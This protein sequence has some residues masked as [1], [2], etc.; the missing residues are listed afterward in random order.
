MTVGYFG[1]IH[2]NDPRKNRIF[3][4][5]QQMLVLSCYELLHMKVRWGVGKTILFFLL[6]KKRKCQKL[7]GNSL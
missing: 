2:L 1:M 7:I 4:L 6:F 5:V 3:I